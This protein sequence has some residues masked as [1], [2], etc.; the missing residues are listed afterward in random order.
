MFLR[1]FSVVLIVALTAAP[2]A[3]CPTIDDL[4]DFN[5]SQTGKITI[6]GDSF[7]N[8]VGDTKNG[9]GY[10]GR[11]EDN[12]QS[13]RFTE[14]GVNGITTAK[15]LSNFKRFLPRGKTT[16]KRTINSDILI[17]DVGRN[18]YWRNVPPSMVVRNIKRLVK[19]LKKALVEDEIESPPKIFVSALLPT[20]R[21]FQ[22]PFIREVNRL[23]LKQKGAKL[24]VYLR[25]DKVSSSVVGADGLHPTARGYKRIAKFLTKFLKGAAQN[26]MRKNRKDTDADG[27][28]DFFETNRYGTDPEA[29]DT[30]GDAKSDGT[31]IFTD[32]TD[33]LDPLA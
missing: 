21:G 10:V 28:Y 19:F 7:V 4:I 9:A 23:L 17:I 13:F 1:I 8:G 33:P 2:A 22:A 20:K 6:T 30:D 25:F 3:A 15:L 27:V 26:K 31:E 14:T 24:P 16:Y 32:G 11:A 18:D 5:C 29:F 12:F